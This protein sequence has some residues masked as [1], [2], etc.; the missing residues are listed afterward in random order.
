MSEPGDCI[1]HVFEDVALAEP[2][3][4]SDNDWPVVMAEGMGPCGAALNLLAGVC[5]EGLSESARASAL[6]QLASI[7][8]HAE[9]VRLRLT[10]A[11]AGPKP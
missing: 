11:V 9:A 4:A 2:P 1:E 5:P 6:A 7:T 10:A 3:E 8:A